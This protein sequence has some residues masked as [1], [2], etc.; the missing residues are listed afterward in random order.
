MPNGIWYASGPYRMDERKAVS[1]FSKGDLL[2]LSSSSLSRINPYAVGTGTQYAIANADSTDSIKDGKVSCLR[3]L[4]DTEF[5][6]RLQAGDTLVT[7]GESSL[8]FVVGT[9]GRY[10]A[11]T[12]V[13][14]GA[15]ASVV[16]VRG[17]D[18]IDQSVQSK[19]IIKFKFA[20]S[21]LDLS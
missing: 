7:G 18:D 2:T 4:P 11:D 21:E 14:S 9:D 20:D 6:C 13:T 5:W 8:S 15:S 17:T 10:F 16:C 12:T 1:A 3:I 19:V